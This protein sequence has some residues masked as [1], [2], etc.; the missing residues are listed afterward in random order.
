MICTTYVVYLQRWYSG[1]L[2][3]RV[4]VMS[5]SK[6]QKIS[7]ATLREAL[8]ALRKSKQIIE[9]HPPSPHLFRCLT[10]YSPLLF[11]FVFMQLSP[12]SSAMI[13][14]SFFTVMLVFSSVA[15]P[16]FPSFHAISLLPVYPNPC[17][18]VP[19]PVPIT[20]LCSSRHGL[21]EHTRA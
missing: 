9:K 18:L 8:V 19:F 1:S 13:T 6:L 21:L 4:S 5:N 16:C 15:S 20:P 2:R 3:S 11:L 7:G 10:S 12:V 17:C 14:P